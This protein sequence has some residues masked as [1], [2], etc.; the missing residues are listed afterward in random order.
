MWNV[1]IMTYIVYSSTP[2]YTII[3]F[4]WKT[5]ASF[6][7]WRTGS[8][9]SLTWFFHVF[10]KPIMLLFIVMTWEHSLYGLFTPYFPLSTSCCEEVVWH[11]VTHPC[12]QPKRAIARSWGVRKDCRNGFQARI[13]GIHSLKHFAWKKR[14]ARAII[15]CSYFRE[16]KQR[17]IKLGGILG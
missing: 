11:E 16:I 10:S 2:Q 14:T 12:V 8:L 7:G 13:R 17:S 3:V 1:N 4:H 5:L 9:Y 6:M 15:Y